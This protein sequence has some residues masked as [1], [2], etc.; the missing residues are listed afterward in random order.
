MRDI[1]ELLRAIRR[2]EKEQLYVNAEKTVRMA[3]IGAYSTQY[4][5]KALRYLIFEKYGIFVDIFEGDYNGIVNTLMDEQSEYY[6]FYPEVTILIPDHTILDISFYQRIWDKIPGHIFQSNFVMPSISPFGNLDANLT[7]SCF[8]KINE[9]N[10][11]LIRYKPKHVT[12]VNLEGLSSEIGKGKWFDYPSYFSS[13]QGFSLELLEDV[14]S[15]FVRQ[16]GALYGRINK[17]LVLDLD[18][19][20]WDGVVGEDGWDGINLDPNDP[21]GEAYRYFQKYVLSLKERGVILSVC[22]KNELKTAEEPFYKNQNMILKRTDI[23]CFIA[24]WEDKASNL[25]RIAD[26]LNIGIDSL[27]FFDDNPAER[28]LI[29]MKLSDVTVIDVPPDPAYYAKA[30]SDSGAFDWIQF[31]EEDR[32][33]AH[34]YQ[35]Q[36]NREKLLAESVDYEQYL[37]ALEMVYKVDFLDPSRV[38]RFVQLINKTNQFNLRTKR[39]TE[40]QIGEMLTNQDYKLIYAELT[41]KFD[42]YG[43]ISC[44]ILRKNFIDTWV[45]S[46]RVFKRHVEN[47]M[48]TFILEHT[49]GTLIGEYLPSKRNIIVSDFYQEIGFK[50][51]TEKGVYIYERNE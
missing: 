33:R 27:V 21:V 35:S 4:V 32:A 43:L 29:R 51:T 18:H 8:F 22:S 48:F 34:T 2:A 17:C 49:K 25:R 45:M 47:K 46:C 12:L 16:F 11:N 10:L 31:T 37:A 50:A 38:P 1:A 24:N 41:D 19:T 14:C 23:A 36:Q 5:V 44:V 13:K 15:L 9:A 30:L 3:V 6:L 39:Y 28:E 40:A 20:L 42:R 7:Y 26:N